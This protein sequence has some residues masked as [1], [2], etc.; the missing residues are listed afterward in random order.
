MTVYAAVQPDRPTDD[1]KITAHALLP[2]S[3]RQDDHSGG[4]SG[5]IFVCREHSTDGGPH[6][7]DVEVVPAHDGRLD[8]LDRA[9]RLESEADVCER[10]QTLQGAAVPLV[11]VVRV[12]RAPELIAAPRASRSRA[13]PTH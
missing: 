4:E 13:Q 1:G 6:A 7:K 12:R 8:L 3:M 10:G 2:H 11:D 9:V 5:S